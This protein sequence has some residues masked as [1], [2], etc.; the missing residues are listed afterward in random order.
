MKKKKIMEEIDIFEA[1]VNNIRDLIIDTKEND[2]DKLVNDL[3]MEKGLTIIFKIC[4]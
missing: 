2:Y 4:F 3:N 1:T